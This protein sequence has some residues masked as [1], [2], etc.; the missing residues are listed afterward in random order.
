V[1]ASFFRFVMIRAFDRRTE[2]LVDGLT[3]G[4]VKDC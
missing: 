2:V 3:T 1:Y 4:V